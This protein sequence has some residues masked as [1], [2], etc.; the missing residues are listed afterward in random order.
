MNPRPM[1][2]TTG[3]TA[4]RTKTQLAAF[5][6][7]AALFRWRRLHLRAAAATSQ[8]WVLCAIMTLFLTGASAIALRAI[9]AI[10]AFH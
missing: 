9:G 8:F 5:P 3:P 2:T 10:T 1:L 4:A 7:I 6:R